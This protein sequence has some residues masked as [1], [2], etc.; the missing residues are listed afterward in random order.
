MN[1]DDAQEGV[2]KK[3]RHLVSDIEE[4]GYEVV[5]ITLYRVY[6]GGILINAMRTL[7]LFLKLVDVMIRFVTLTELLE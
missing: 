5:Y 1:V 6:R 4:N 3:C 7:K 2:N